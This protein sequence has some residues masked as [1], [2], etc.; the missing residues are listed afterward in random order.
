M[1]K[2]LLISILAFSLFFTG[3]TAKSVNAT[4]DTITNISVIE[5]TD[6]SSDA[7]KEYMSNPVSLETPV[8]EYGESTAFIHMDDDI[9]IRILYPEG[10]LEAFDSSIEQWVNETAEFYQQEASGSHKDGETAELTTNYSSY[11]A[12]NKWVS[13]KIS[14]LFDKPY[15]AH[16]VDIIHTFNANLQTGEPVKL[17]DLLFEGG[18][19]AIEKLVIENAGISAEEIDENLLDLWLLK[20]EGLEIT[21]RRGD[22]LPMSDGTVTLIFTYDELKDVLTLT[23]NEPG[24]LPNEINTDITKSADT[25]ISLPSLSVDP[26]KPMVALTFDDGPSKHTNRLLDI[27]TEYGGKGT[28][29][30]V[31][32][33]LDNR[34]ETLKRIASEDHQIAGHS[35]DHRQLTKLTGDDLINQVMATRA[36]IYD[37]T[38]IDTPVLRPPYGSFNDEVK[39]V[40]K[41]HGVI[42]VNWSIDTLDWKYK[43]T[44]TIYNTIMANVK[45]GDIILCHDIH[46]TTVD[47]METVIP[48]LIENGYQLVTVSELLTAGNREITAGE[49]YT[50]K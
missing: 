33:I 7:L 1:K 4:E 35:W 34:S 20:P 19:E 32:N 9:V 22:Y 47:A 40:C 38:G 2:N 5:N 6:T 10:E 39:Q 49:V 50:R 14:G 25:G 48:A 45:D 12:E 41:D 16:P 11:I 30:V 29:F 31:G 15:L 43:D 28:F 44:N 8:H 46:G 36:K 13:V 18:R 26:T 42:I 17:D 37:I 24:P 23:G 3:C 27:F 21:L